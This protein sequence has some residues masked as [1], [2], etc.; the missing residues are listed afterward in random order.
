MIRAA[1]DTC[2]GW[3]CGLLFK[4]FFASMSGLAGFTAA[5]MVELNRTRLQDLLAMIVKIQESFDLF[6]EGAYSKDGGAYLPNTYKF[7]GSIND[8]ET[9]YAVLVL[10]LGAVVAAIGV[11]LLA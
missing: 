2:H 4:L 8:D 1:D 7:V 11:L 6:V 3:F 5:A 10:K 9:N